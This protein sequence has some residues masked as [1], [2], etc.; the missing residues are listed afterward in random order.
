MQL[1]WPTSDQELIHHAVSTDVHDV[2]RRMSSSRR[3]LQRRVPQ[4]VLTGAPT[5]PSRLRAV[6][7]LAARERESRRLALESFRYRVGRPTFIERMKTEESTALM[8]SLAN[9]LKEEISTLARREVRRQT[10]PADKAMV[11][12]AR[13]IAALKREIQALEHEL[14]SLG[15]PLPGPTVPPKKPSDRA[16]PSRRAASKVSATSTSAKP[17][18]RNQFSG[19]ALKAH[20][21]RLG[22]SADNYGKLLGAAGMSIYNWEQGKTRPRKSSVDAW[23]AIRRID[24]REAAQRLASLKAAEP[25]SESKQAPAE[26]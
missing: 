18:P 6:P 25:K 24:R 8:A 5:I 12:C 20:R 1:V 13:D 17:A 16:P 7:Y 2:R 26:K 11:R 10:A 21:E 22:L 23:S 14:G 3:P 19:E 9:A 15:T 4:Y